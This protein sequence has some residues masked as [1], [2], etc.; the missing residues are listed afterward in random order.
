LQEINLEKTYPDRL[1]AVIR[2]RRAGSIPA[3]ILTGY[4]PLKHVP[5]FYIQGR[6]LDK[7]KINNDDVLKKASGGSKISGCYSPCPPQ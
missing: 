4:M 1:L 6:F 2:H 7:R 5:L 3:G